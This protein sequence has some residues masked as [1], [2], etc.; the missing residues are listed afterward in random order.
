MLRG[1]DTPPG[2]NVPELQTPLPGPWGPFS[3]LFFFILA[4]LDLVCGSC[5]SVLF[6]KHQRF[7]VFC[8]FYLTPALV[9]VVVV[10]EGVNSP[11]LELLI[12]SAH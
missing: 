9:V 4:P 1:A 3:L 10:V 7:F 5:V 8:P 2:G 12:L 6:S 11:T